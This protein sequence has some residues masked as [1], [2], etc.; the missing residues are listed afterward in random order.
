M[1]DARQ[2]TYTVEAYNLS[3]ASENKIHDDT[4]ASK[5]GFKGGLVPG[6]EVFAYATHPALEHFGPTFLE[7]GEMECRFAKPVYDGATATVTAAGQPDGSLGISVES[8]GAHCA[9]GRAV[10]PFSAPAPVDPASYELRLPP[11]PDARPPADEQSLAPGR[12]LCTTPEELTAEA[13]AGYLRDVRET[14]P[15]YVDE[16]IAHPG[17][18]LRLCNSALKDNVALAP[19]IH[20]GSRIRNFATARVGEVLQAR[21]RVTANTEKKGHRFVDMDCLLLAGDKPVAHVAHTA[22]Y[23]LRHLAS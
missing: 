11:A 3:H 9:T 10:L 16:G 7:R 17:I 23:R 4:V 12:V 18:L 14:N 2:L 19:W 8:Q 1:Q 15:L 6:V 21:T 5:L 22:I 20:V 13:L